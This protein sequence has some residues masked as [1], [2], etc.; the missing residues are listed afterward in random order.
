[1]DEYRRLLAIQSIHEDHVREAQAERRSH[2]L[3]GRS[4]HDYITLSRLGLVVTLLGIGLFL[5]WAH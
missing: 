5:F 1:M 2:W 3:L 4:R